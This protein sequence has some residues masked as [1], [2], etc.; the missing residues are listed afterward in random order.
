ML[1]DSKQILRNLPPSAA[2][3]S[4][5]FDLSREVCD[6]FVQWDRD[7]QATHELI[8][9]RRFD[10]ALTLAATCLKATPELFGDDLHPRIVCHLLAGLSQ[11]GLQRYAAAVTSF[12]DALNLCASEPKHTETKILLLGN[13]ASTL[14]TLE[15]HHDA[16]HAYSQRLDLLQHASAHQE[17]DPSLGRELKI[18]TLKELSALCL[19]TG[20][21]NDAEG[22][23]YQLAHLQAK[24]IEL[25]TTLT[26]LA[27]ILRA[28]GNNEFAL[29][30]AKKAQTEL[31]EGGAEYY[32]P[33]VLA[34]S[35]MLEGRLLLDQQKLTEARNRYE[36][37]R[38]IL[39]TVLGKYNFRTLLCACDIA[40][41]DMQ[42]EDFLA[43]R[44]VFKTCLDKAVQLSDQS[45]NDPIL[46]PYLSAHA[47]LMHLIG[48]RM[49]QAVALIEKLPPNKQNFGGVAAGFEIPELVF[50]WDQLRSTY[51][52][53]VTEV[54][55]DNGRFNTFN[56][57]VM[58]LKREAQDHL[59]MALSRYIQTLSSLQAQFGTRHPEIAAVYEKL[60]TLYL[61]MG[62]KQLSQRCDLQAAQ[63]R[64]EIHEREGG[65]QE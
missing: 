34:N 49:I 19:T 2:V 56:T 18:E 29:S 35:M 41:I 58:A 21:L 22:F 51:V 32:E 26:L 11:H 36:Q 40:T 64:R 20:L 42:R 5:I 3:T 17:V 10:E 9:L 52:D 61:T 62:D 59:G 55:R 6:R 27:E 28:A 65:K 33:L 43:S 14:T 45:S 8:G 24:G 50:L 57:F 12:Q 16:I 30:C 13:I 46:R 23:C 1:N 25:G 47:A 15:Q 53:Y 39:T 37:A 38:Q 48:D 7:I 54:A 63:I 44:D 31:H 4:H 60:S